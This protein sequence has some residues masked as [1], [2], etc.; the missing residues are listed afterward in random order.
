MPRVPG[1]YGLAGFDADVTHPCR[2]L[3]GAL[4]HESRAV[5]ERSERTKRYR[6]SLAVATSASEESA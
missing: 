1:G 5:S 4:M 6:A 3:R 2:H